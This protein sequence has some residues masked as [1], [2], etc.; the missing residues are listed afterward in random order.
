M[1]ETEQH[2][3]I[4]AQEPA[5]SYLETQWP[6]YRQTGLEELE[7]VAGLASA[8]HT[9]LGGNPPDLDAFT[10]VAVSLDA[11]YRNL[12]VALARIGAAVSCAGSA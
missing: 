6:A 12:G 2:A 10:A 5:P 8:A 4:A 3:N 7:H 1:T 9:I 11:H